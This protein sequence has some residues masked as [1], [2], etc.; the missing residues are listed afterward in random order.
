MHPPAISIR[1]SGI[2]R[3]MMEP[4]L[5]WMVGNASFR[6]NLGLR[7]NHATRCNWDLLVEA[8]HGCP[9]RTDV[10]SPTFWLKIPSSCYCMHL[11]NDLD[12]FA[13]S[14]LLCE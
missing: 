13:T 11:S 2:A 14:L 1:C 9:P 5:S 12:S 10:Y 7:K 4:E 8:T 6:A 3:I